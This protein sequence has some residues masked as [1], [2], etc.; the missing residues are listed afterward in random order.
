M[1]EGEKKIRKVALLVVAAILFTSLFVGMAT[2]E[3]Q[4]QKKIQQVQKEHQIAEEKYKQV[5]QV[6]QSARI[7]QNEAFQNY[8]DIKATE[9]DPQALLDAAKRYVQNTIDSMI[10]HL[11]ALK[12]NAENAAQEGYAPDQEIERIKTHIARLEEIKQDVSDANTMQEIQNTVQ[13]LRRE[14]RAM[15]NEAR[16]FTSHKAIRHIEIFLAK[17]DTIPEKIESVIGQLEDAGADT[18]G[19][20]EKFDRF[21]E[22]IDAAE[23]AYEKAKE[24]YQKRNGFDPSGQITNTAASENS[25]S[26]M[27]S[28]LREAN[29]HARE[30]ARILKDI[31]NEIRGY[32]S[33]VFLNGTGTLHAEGDGRAAIF[34]NV[35]IDVSAENATIFVSPNADVTTEGEGTEAELGRHNFFEA[36]PP[37]NSY[38][39]FEAWPSKWIKYPGVGSA[40]VSGEH[41]RFI[42]IGDGIVLDATGSGKALLCGNGTYYPDKD[43]GTTHPWITPGAEVMTTSEVTATATETPGEEEDTEEENGE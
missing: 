18:T 34:G 1:K 41:I 20:R 19:L 33:V 30:A 39:F 3:P 43:N 6:Y 14:W 15:K 13:E 37:Q 23:E 38:H 31:F 29:M 4:A 9:K 5:R 40:T 35:T 24:I 27:N 36:W 22:E 8:R 11:E 10:A 7:R 17:A 42:I 28:Y 32:R 21:N 26:E 25:L 12:E 2:A 16:Y